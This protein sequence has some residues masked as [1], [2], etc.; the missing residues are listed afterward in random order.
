MTAKTQAPT[1]QFF[2]LDPHL[3]LKCT[4]QN[5]YMPTGEIHQLNSYENRVFEIKL[6]EQKSIIAK[7]FRP[8]RWSKE[9]IEDEHQFCFDLIADGLSVGTPLKSKN[10][11][12]VFNADG[13]LYCFYE[14]VR[15][16]MMQEVLLNQFERLGSLTAQLHNTG[17]K[18]EA[19]HRNFFGPTQDNKWTVLDQL[20]DVI[21]PEIRPQYIELAEHVFNTLDE[22]LDPQGFIRIHGDLH[23]GNLLDNGKDDITIVDFDDF[24]NG[25]VVQDFWMIFP[26]QDFAPT[27]EFELF[28]KGYETL[29]HFDQRQME[30]VPY[31]RAYRVIS[32]AG[33]ILNRW[34]DPSFPKIFPQFNTYTYWAEEFDSLRKIIKD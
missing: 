31:L 30:L 24:L 12:S 29:R 15:G 6:E 16:R 19:M 21:V 20:N 34:N 5:G 1:D 32:Y 9:T 28:L 18:K 10:G 8:Q 22:K 17:E 26:D 25:P 23:R 27:Q 11:E 2:S 33:W 4:D 13:I 14:K 7:F 3:I